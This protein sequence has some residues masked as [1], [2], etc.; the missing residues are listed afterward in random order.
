[1]KKKREFNINDERW[2][3]DETRNYKNQIKSDIEAQ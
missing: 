1:M 2:S 3:Y